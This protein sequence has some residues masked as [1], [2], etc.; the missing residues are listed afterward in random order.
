MISPRSQGETSSTSLEGSSDTINQ[1]RKRGRREK[2]SP[3]REDDTPSM[4]KKQLTKRLVTL[5][6]K[7][8][9]ALAL[10]DSMYCT[11][12]KEMVKSERDL[13]SI[14]SIMPHAVESNTRLTQ[15]SADIESRE[16]ELRLLYTERNQISHSVGRS[17]ML[18]LGLDPTG[19]P[20][21][22][23]IYY[24]LGADNKPIESN[25]TEKARVSACL[26]L[27]KANL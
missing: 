23:K 19:L 8:I 12:S 22:E 16:K 3:M 2:G 10:K 21:M 26:E 5:E 14:E 25:E 11:F 15:V 9:D 13:I 18:V 20:F 7:I 27:V 24:A 4:K 6:Q 17:K 1:K